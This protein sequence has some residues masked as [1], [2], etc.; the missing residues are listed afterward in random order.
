MSKLLTKKSSIVGKGHISVLDFKEALS[1]CDE[2]VFFP[3]G[4][5]QTRSPFLKSGCPDSKTLAT[6]YLIIGYIFHQ[7]N[8]FICES[9]NYYNNSLYFKL[10][11]FMVIKYRKFKGVSI[12]TASKRVIQQICKR[13]RVSQ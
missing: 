5:P 12:A 9:K 13:K 10:N 6:P 4:Y 7:K 2:A 1:H 8:R 3:F 11:H